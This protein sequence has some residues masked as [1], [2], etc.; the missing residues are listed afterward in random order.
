MGG[1]SCPSFIPF[2][3]STISIGIQRNARKA[4]LVSMSSSTQTRR[5]PKP[6]RRS[7]LASSCMIAVAHVV[8]APFRAEAAVII[9][10]ERFGDKGK[11]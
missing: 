2:S 3:T 1:T 11:V 8:T 9:D 5:V 6:C 7:F 4:A 10:T